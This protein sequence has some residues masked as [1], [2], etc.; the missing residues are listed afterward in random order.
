MKTENNLNSL[1]PMPL[2]KAH[3]YVSFAY[4]L[5]V[6][7]AGLGYSMQFIGLYPFENVSFLS[8]GRIRMIH[9]QAVA[10]AW[11]ANIFF[12]IMY[13]MIPKLTKKP[14]LSEKFG[15]FIFWGYNTLIILTV[16][17]ILGGQAQGIE[18]G[19]TP[20]ILDPFIAI[21]VVMYVVNITTSIWRGRANPYYVTVWYVLA[22]LIWTPPVY[23]MGNFL[24]E[25]VFAGS[26]GATITSMYIHDLVGLFVTPIGTGMVYYLLPVL[27]KRPLYSHA[28]SLIGFW[29]LAFFYPMNSAHH[30]LYSPI[31]MWAQYASIVASVGVHVVVYTVVFNII[32]TMAGDWKKVL[33]SI[34]LKFILVGAFSY[35]VTCIQCAIQ[36]TLAVQEVIH[37][38][39][40]VVGHAHL[41]LFGTFSFWAFAWMYYILPKVA[42]KPIYSNSLV[43]WHF[44]LSTIGII[45]MDIDLMAAGLVQ[46]SLWGNLSPFIDSVIASKPYW[47]VRTISGTAIFVGVVIFV[48][49]ALMTIY[50]EDNRNE[51]TNSGEALA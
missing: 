7:L 14:I 39:D 10:Y 48:V 21:F 37:F 8:P 45:V 18:W 50:G 35:L 29:G 20:K 2:V 9:T 34:P 23:L 19:E 16:V 40:W 1:V 28:L 25:Y 38:T 15:W 26:G 30:Y 6:V 43:S 51:D 5:V 42:K 22:G 36:V 17:L 13:Y 46:G 11:I 12:A 27:M 24:P 44:W 4:I 31:P 47:W 33:E 3:M 49:N 41:V 32:A